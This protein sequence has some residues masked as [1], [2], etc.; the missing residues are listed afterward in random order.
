M[1]RLS[2]ALSVSPQLLPSDL[3]DVA[4]A[5]YRGVVNNRPD[6]EEPGQ[7]RSAE[8]EAEAERL[9]LHYAHIPI[10]PGKMTEADAARFSEALREAGGPVL[11]FCRTGSR[12]ANLYKLSEQIRGPM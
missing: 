8:L 5:G 3:P 7:P 6:A 11:A 12:S 2:P 10:V 1:I 4:A 9:G